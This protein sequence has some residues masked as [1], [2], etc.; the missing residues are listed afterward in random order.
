MSQIGI[1]TG[2]GAEARLLTGKGWLVG[3][4]GGRP[5]RAR[6]LALDM[7]RSGCTALVSF[8]IAGGLQPGLPP[9]TVIIGEDVWSTAG[10]HPCDPAGIERWQ[11]ALP[12]A[13]TGR[14]AASDVV[15]TNA[16][17]KA[18]LR[19]SSGALAVDMESWAVAE[20]AAATGLPFTILRALADP[21]ERALPPAAAE[22]LDEHG[23]VR[24][25]AI[26]LSLLKDPTQLPGLIRVGLDT[27]A[28]LAA[29]KRALLR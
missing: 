27:N 9:G 4:A 2:F 15:V 11:Q 28:A 7:A 17:D 18:A 5:D 20:A 8:G 12:Q 10:T 14:I 23:N 26:L 13:R 19:L 25:G 16:A 21:A 3:M 29:L 1:I 6:E 22:G 24:L